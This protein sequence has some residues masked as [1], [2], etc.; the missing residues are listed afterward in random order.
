MKN[1]ITKILTLSLVALML[2]LSVTTFK[3]FT[4]RGTPQVEPPIIASAAVPSLR[5]DNRTINETD[6]AANRQTSKTTFRFGKGIAK[7]STKANSIKKVQDKQGR[8]PNQEHKTNELETEG[9]EVSVKNL[10]PNGQC[11]EEKK[12]NE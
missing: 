6:S 3:P 8:L 12:N 10:C 1:R 9:E 7:Q 5:D 4:R 11:Q 2:M